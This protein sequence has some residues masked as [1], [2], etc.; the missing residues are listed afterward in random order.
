MHFSLHFLFVPIFIAPITFWNVSTNCF[1]LILFSY[2]FHA[3]PVVFAPF[4][5]IYRF[6]TIV[7][8]VVLIAYIVVYSNVSSFE[9]LF[10]VHIR[11]I[12]FV[13]CLFVIYFFCLYGCFCFKTP[14]FCFVSY[15]VVLS[16]FSCSFVFS[17]CIVVFSC[18]RY[19]FVRGRVWQTAVVGARDQHTWSC[20]PPPD[21]VSQMLSAALHSCARVSA[22]DGIALDRRRAR[23]CR[24][25]LLTDCVRRCAR[26]WLAALAPHTWHCQLCAPAVLIV[27]VPPPYAVCLLY[28]VESVE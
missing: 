5:H 17:C 16:R 7:L 27:I 9:I 11:I 3:F 18:P 10:L 1:V 14:L 28:N 21:C 12:C 6:K 24:T 25:Q 8:T 23:R 19:F 13:S 26:P 15:Y 20:A 4:L 2:R 22:T